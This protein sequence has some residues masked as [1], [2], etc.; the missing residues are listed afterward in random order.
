MLLLG[1]TIIVQ[2]A[3]FNDESLDE[4]YERWD[5]VFASMAVNKR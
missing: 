5:N 2:W 1:I 4:W 3:I